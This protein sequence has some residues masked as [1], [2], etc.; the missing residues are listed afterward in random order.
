MQNYKI[1][2]FY[3]NHYEK[4]KTAHFSVQYFKKTAHFS[5]QF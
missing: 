1:L 3:I 4:L 5:V 2:K